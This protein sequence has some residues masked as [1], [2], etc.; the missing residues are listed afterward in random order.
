ME[1]RF[2]TWADGE[3]VALLVLVTAIALVL[4]GADALERCHFPSA[5]QILLEDEIE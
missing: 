2:W 5:E 1:Y 3:L 4:F